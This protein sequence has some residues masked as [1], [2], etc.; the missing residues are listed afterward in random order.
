[1]GADD[2]AAVGRPA[3]VEGELPAVG[4]GRPEQPGNAYRVG[5]AGDL[6]RQFVGSAGYQHQLAHR[7]QIFSQRVA[8]AVRRDQAG[9]GERFQALRRAQR[10]DTQH[11][12]QGLAV[13]AGVEPFAGMDLQR[14]LDRLT[15][16]TRTLP[17]QAGHVHHLVERGAGRADGTQRR[18]PGQPRCQRGSAHCPC[19]EE[20]SPTVG[21]M[22]IGYAC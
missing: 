14:H 12:R 7:D 2:D 11:Q 9:V 16:F 19:Q 4:M 13:A 17:P 20:G 10:V 21:S 3:R 1:M 18:T 22:F 5:L 15:A 6:D 8:V